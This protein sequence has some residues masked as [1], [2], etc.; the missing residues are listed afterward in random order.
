MHGCLVWAPL[1]EYTIEVGDVVQS[2]A[3]SDLGA[4]GGP[5]PL[6]SGAVLNYTVLHPSSANEQCFAKHPCRHSVSDV[7]S[8]PVPQYAQFP[9]IT[10]PPAIGYG[11]G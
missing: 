1:V 4:A 5:A 11:Y 6:P 2:E 8:S 9:V 3:K 7:I 10:Y